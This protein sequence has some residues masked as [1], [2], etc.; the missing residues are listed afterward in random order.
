MYWLRLDTRLGTAVFK[1]TV[2][3]VWQWKLYCCD[4]DDSHDSNENSKN[5]VIIKLKMTHHYI[6]IAFLCD[7]FS[8]SNAKRQKYSNSNL[9]YPS[10]G[11]T[12]FFSMPK[13]FFCILRNAKSTTFRHTRQNIKSFQE[14]LLHFC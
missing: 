3:T 13:N 6:F 1:I 5:G 2:P 10:I 14:F 12:C 4:S 9:V 7:N 11:K 8:Q